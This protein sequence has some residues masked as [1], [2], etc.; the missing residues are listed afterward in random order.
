MAVRPRRRDRSRGR[1]PA[2]DA[3]DGGAAKADGIL[4]ANACVA[5]TKMHLLRVSFRCSDNWQWAKLGGAQTS[6]WLLRL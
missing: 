3:Y 5:P 4:A 6:G 1:G 2:V